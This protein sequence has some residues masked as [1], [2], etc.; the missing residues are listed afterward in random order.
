MGAYVLHQAFKQAQVIARESIKDPRL[1]LHKTILSP[2]GQLTSQKPLCTAHTL[3]Q[4]HIYKDNRTWKV[5]MHGSLDLKSCP[6]NV[7]CFFILKKKE[8]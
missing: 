7:E 3:S 2:C 6:P 8:I 1:F 5:I 4:T